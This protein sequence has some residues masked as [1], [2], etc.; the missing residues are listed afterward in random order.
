[1]RLG[2]PTF[3]AFTHP[4]EWVAELRRLEYGAA[5]CP[6]DDAADSATIQAYARAAQAAGIVIAE[7]G[8]WNNPLSVDPDEQ[9]AAIHLCQ[10]RLALADAI[11]ARCC[12]NIAGSRGAVWDGPHPD[13]FGEDTFDAIVATTRE[14][15]D[16]VRPTRAFYTLETMPW[17]APDTIDSYERLIRAVQR[18]AF[19]VHLDPVNLIT[20]PRLLYRSDDF[21]RECFAR[22]GPHIRSCHAKDAALTGRFVSHID[23]VRPGLGILDY[24][25][26][27]TE[28]SELDDDTPIML[29]HLEGEHEYAAAAA[30]LRGVAARLGLSFKIG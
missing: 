29:E 16:A 12:V 27:L 22:L 21:L 20:S 1:M 10:R 15:I 23:E 3:R 9:R 4:E 19:A 8:V 25:T 6:V 28:L 26:F 11:G 24:E 17:I 14:I 30:H 13:N 2:G 18:R 5:Y 7:V